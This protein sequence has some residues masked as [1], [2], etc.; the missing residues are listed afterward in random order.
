MSDT[1][2]DVPGCAVGVPYRMLVRPGD[3]YV[4]YLHMPVDDRMETLCRRMIQ[5]PEDLWTIP[6][7]NPG[8]AYNVS[9]LEKPALVRVQGVRCLRAFRSPAN[10]E[11][12]KSIVALGSRSSG[13]TGPRFDE[14]RAAAEI[15]TSWRILQ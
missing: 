3:G 4:Q 8:T 6:P 2:P 10:I 5:K 9:D 1:L 13:Q 7:A 11:L 12:L 15:L 14:V